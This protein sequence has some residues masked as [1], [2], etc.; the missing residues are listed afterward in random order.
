MSCFRLAASYQ[1]HTDTSQR[2]ARS[3]WLLKYKMPEILRLPTDTPLRR[4]FMY[5]TKL[6]WATPPW[7]TEAMRA[8]MKDIYESCPPT[9]NVDHIVPLDSKI[10]CGLHVP[11]NLQHLSFEENM[12]KS[13]KWWP[14]HPFENRDL[15]D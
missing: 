6:Y 10:V 9:H 2:P 11:W 14:D 1:G 13:N 3:P 7:L 12:R 4:S 15:F 5:W 8:E